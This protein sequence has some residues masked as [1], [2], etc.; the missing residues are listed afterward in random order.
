[1][2]EDTVDRAGADPLRRERA[3]QRRQ[4]LQNATS[5]KCDVCSSEREIIKHEAYHFLTVARVARPAPGRRGVVNA[6]IIPSIIIAIIR[7][8]T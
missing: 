3:V 7:S 1:M 5:E 4:G 2:Q 6:Y 8:L